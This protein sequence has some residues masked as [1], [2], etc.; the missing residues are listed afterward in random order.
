MFNPPKQGPELLIQTYK[1][2]TLSIF[3]KVHCSFFE[4]IWLYLLQTVFDTTVLPPTVTN[5][6]PQILSGTAFILTVFLTA[7]GIVRQSYPAE[8]PSICFPSGP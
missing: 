7:P 4:K 6:R 8:A 3:F 2:G 1:I 5:C